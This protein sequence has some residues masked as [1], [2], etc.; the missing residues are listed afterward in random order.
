MRQMAGSTIGLA[1]TKA[2]EATAWY[3]AS[4]PSF[5]YEGNKPSS[6]EGN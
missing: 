2:C 6:P 5:F 1:P 4:L 3:N